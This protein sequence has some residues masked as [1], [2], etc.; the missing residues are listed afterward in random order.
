VGRTKRIAI[1]T[2]AT[3][4]GI[5]RLDLTTAAWRDDAVYLLG[6]LKDRD[7]EIGRL[8]SLVRMCCAQGAAPSGLDI[9]H[10]HA[11]T[12]LDQVRTCER[13]LAAAEEAMRDPAK[14]DAL[15]KN[16][17]LTVEVDDGTNDGRRGPE[18]H[19]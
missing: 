5:D 12:V 14:V 11:P 9:A 1:K 8:K 4:D 16:W 7:A 2:E 6:K 15:D 13:I 17:H 18:S 10:G 19:S 3:K